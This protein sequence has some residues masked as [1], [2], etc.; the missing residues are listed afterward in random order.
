M[1]NFK[2]FK[3]TK[4]RESDFRLELRSQDRSHHHIK[5]ISTQRDTLVD[6]SSF[7]I[8]NTTNNTNMSSSI[9][10]SNNHKHASEQKMYEGD[11]IEALKHFFKKNN[12]SP[13]SNYA[14]KNNKMMT[15]HDSSMEDSVPESVKLL[16]QNDEYDDVEEASDENDKPKPTS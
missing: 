9:T 2:L 7:D 6:N 1:S 11:S 16:Q 5:S 13:S 4:K 15:P 12:D 14:D 8:A 3:S 10:N